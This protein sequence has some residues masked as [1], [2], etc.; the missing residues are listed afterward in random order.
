[1]RNNKNKIQSSNHNPI[2]FFLRKDVAVHND[3]EMFLIPIDI[4]KRFSIKLENYI[5]VFNIV[6]WFLYYLYRTKKYPM[7]G[8]HGLHVTT[9]VFTPPW[10][11]REGR[12]RW[13]NRIGS[14]L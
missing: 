5:N 14:T 13:I 10:R 1:M 8:I 2:A 11:G 9:C 3:P 4:L 7:R 6:T 12:F